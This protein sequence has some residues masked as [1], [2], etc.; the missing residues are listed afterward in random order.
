MQ[1]TDYKATIKGPSAK[2]TY[3]LHFVE[4]HYGYEF[5]NNYTL[6]AES[7]LVLNSKKARV[8]ELNVV[9]GKRLVEIKTDQAGP[10][11]LICE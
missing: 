3:A 5:K 1:P 10:V 11:T 8:S 7:N 9:E 4:N 2:G 6:K